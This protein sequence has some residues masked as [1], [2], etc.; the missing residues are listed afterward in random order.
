MK[1][2]WCSLCDLPKGS[3]SLAV[4]ISAGVPTLDR[5]KNTNLIFS[6]H[7]ISSTATYLQDHL[8]TYLQDHLTSVSSN[9]PGV[10]SN[11]HV[12][13]LPIHY[14]E[15]FFEVQNSLIMFD[16]YGSPNFS[17]LLYTSPSPRDRTRSRMPSSA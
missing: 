12:C 8:A 16:Q 14:N 17:C 3:P 15:L 6:I 4:G 13:P 2:R 7:T 11:T 9:S 5:E 1:S 10:T